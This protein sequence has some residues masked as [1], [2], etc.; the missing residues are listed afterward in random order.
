MYK[1]EFYTIFFNWKL[2][3]CLIQPAVLIFKGANNFAADC[4][5]V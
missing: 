5:P 4:M 2:D 1:I 3:F